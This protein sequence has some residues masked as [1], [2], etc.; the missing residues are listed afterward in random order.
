MGALRSA[1]HAKASGLRVCARFDS[2]RFQSCLVGAA[3]ALA[4]RRFAVGS[5]GPAFTSLF[6]GTVRF[7]NYVG[8]T[9]I[10]ALY[11]ADGLSL[12]AL[13]NAVL[14]P[15]GNVLSVL[16]L[17]RFG[18]HD[19][20]RPR[21]VHAV[22]NVLV[23]AG[24]VDEAQSTASFTVHLRDVR[25]ERSHVFFGRYEYR[26]RR[27]ADDWRIAR[28]KILLLNDVIPTVVDFYSV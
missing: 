6:Q 2:P 25:A 23:E 26:L 27:L 21:V 13:A 4:A 22:T 18:R 14:V 9:I 16:A 10:T 19:G 8:L 15:V 7:N 1:L 28:K 17:A 20:V 3:L 24:G 5:D 12:A 11:A